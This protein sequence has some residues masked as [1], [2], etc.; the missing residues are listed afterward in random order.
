MDYKLVK[1]ENKLQQFPFTVTLGPCSS[2]GQ[3]S[4]PNPDITNDKSTATSN[5]SQTRN[6]F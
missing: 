6:V 3:C 1:R 4:M 2:S 5:P